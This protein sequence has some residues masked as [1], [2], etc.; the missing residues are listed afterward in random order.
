M[1]PHETTIADEPVR[2]VQITDPHLFADENALLAGM[3]CNEGL[4]DVISLVQ[5]HEPQAQLILCTGDIAQD[6]SV[7]AYQRFQAMISSL[8][9]PQRWIAGN[10][11]MPHVI[12][13]ALGKDSPLLEKSLQLGRWKIIL[14]N[15]CLEGHIYGL[16]PQSEL[17]FL[18]R[19]LRQA[20]ADGS[21]IL[22]AVHHN[23]VPVA[24]AWLQNHSLKNSAELLAVTDRHKSVRCIL[25]GHIHQ[26]FQHERNQVLMLGAPSTC[27]QFHPEHD[28]FA[29]DD[30]NPGYR[31]LDMH[32]N[33]N[34]VTG[35]RRVSDK[36]YDVDLNSRGY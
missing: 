31:W 6:A 11:D 7:A 24:A 10:H 3:N 18:S 27:I 8:G 15:S 14:L 5:Q 4:R 35:V 26:D 20:D 17:D 28:H 13:E 1:T 2:L 30:L 33:G 23:P 29:L 22:I 12:S 36:R 9:V 19:E 34:I 21:H 25:F 16:L 32:G